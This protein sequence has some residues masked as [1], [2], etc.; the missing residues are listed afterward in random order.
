VTFWQ[1]L[2]IAAGLALVLYAAVVLTL[3]V[4]G[5]SGDARA[6]ARFVP[7]CVVLFQRLLTDPRVDWWRKALLVVAIAYLASPIDLVPDFIPVA[8]QLDDA[9]VVVLALRL[10]LHGSGERLLIEHW[11]GPR[12]SL[13]LI[14]RLAY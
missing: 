3:V 4:A 14:L 10:L 7:D 1:G 2:L 5:R 13:Q 9:I 6:F 8:G 11:P 12:R